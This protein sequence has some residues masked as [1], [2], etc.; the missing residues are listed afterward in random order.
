MPKKAGVS[1]ESRAKMLLTLKELQQQYPDG[2]TVTRLSQK[3][4]WRN[5]ETQRTVDDLVE[6]GMIYG[7]Y[8]SEWVLTHLKGTILPKSGGYLLKVSPWGDEF[9]SHW[10]QLTKLSEARDH[11]Y[12]EVV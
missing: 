7:D 12:T 5:R 11:Q 8:A 2:C 1:H 3:L 6:S 10:N 4:G 9:L